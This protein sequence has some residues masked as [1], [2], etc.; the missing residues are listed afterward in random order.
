MTPPWDAGVA[1]AGL[2]LRGHIVNGVFRPDVQP[3]IRFGLGLAAILLYC[4]AVFYLNGH[5]RKSLAF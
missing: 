4:S 1:L 2:T 5:R 3:A